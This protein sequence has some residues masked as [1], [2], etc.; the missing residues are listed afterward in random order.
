MGDASILLLRRQRALHDLIK[1]AHQRPQKIRASWN[2]IKIAGVN[3][4]PI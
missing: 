4:L 1:N 2:E 3:I